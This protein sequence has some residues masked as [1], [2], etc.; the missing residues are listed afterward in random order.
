MARRRKKQDD[1]DAGGALEGVAGEIGKIVSGVMGG[2]TKGKRGGRRSKVAAA[3]LNVESD[4]AAATQIRDASRLAKNAVSSWQNALAWDDIRRGWYV[5]D[6]DALDLALKSARYAS[7]RL[8]E[9]V[10]AMED[11]A[12]RG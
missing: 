7:R 2:R 1:Q 10:T 4:N 8:S 6:V 12:S 9:A 11:R 5:R 3:P